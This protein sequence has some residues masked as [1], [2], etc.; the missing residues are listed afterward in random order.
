MVSHA[1]EGGAAQS[2]LLEK[3]AKFFMLEVL[4][5]MEAHRCLQVLRSQQHDFLNHLQV[6]SGLA[7]LGRT[8]ELRA[9]IVEVVREMAAT[10]RI[11]HLK[12]PAV[13]LTLLVLRT[14]AALRE[15]A[16]ELDV[17]TDL[18]RCRVPERV[19][20]QTLT[21]LTDGLLTGASTAGVGRLGLTVSETA[22][23]YRW[24]VRCAG[25]GDEEIEKIM[26]DVEELLRPWGGRAGIREPGVVEIQL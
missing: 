14:E 12:Q 4:P 17:D 11:I 23:G 16:L 10:R 18:G 21:R 8:E 22:S 5:V 25:I 19:L 26:A 24:V 1:E 3:L 20:V 15:V 2:R 7:Q 6:L 13:A 9:Y